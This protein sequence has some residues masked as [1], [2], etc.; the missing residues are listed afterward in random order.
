MIKSLKP[1]EEEVV[2]NVLRILPIAL[3]VRVFIVLFI[4]I[5]I[6][7]GIQNYEN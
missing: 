5:I 6:S 7:D 2:E 3:G 4:F 1:K